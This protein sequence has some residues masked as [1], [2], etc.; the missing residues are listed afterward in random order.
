MT[1]RAKKNKSVKVT[2]TKNY[3]H[4]GNQSS[5]STS[6]TWLHKPAY[7]TP[8]T[9]ADMYSPHCST[10]ITV[11]EHSIPPKK[12]PTFYSYTAENTV[13]PAEVPPPPILIPRFIRPRLALRLIF[14]LSGLQ[15]LL[16]PTLWH[17]W[18]ITIVLAVALVKR[19]MRTTI[20]DF[21]ERLNRLREYFLTCRTLYMDQSCSA[22]FSDIVL[23]VC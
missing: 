11:L 8:A 20:F 16:T 10:E 13:A 23:N 5:N 4:S 21:T 18:I 6:M 7:H 15:K 22:V 17:Q 14:S 19:Y 9:S 3:H 1:D 12:N 2:W